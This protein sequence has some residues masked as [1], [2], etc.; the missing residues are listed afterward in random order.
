MGDPPDLFGA[1]V[2]LF[3]TN[4][5]ALLANF[6]GRRSA[7]AQRFCEALFLGAV[8]GAPEICLAGLMAAGA[9]SAPWLRAQGRLG[10]V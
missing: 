10:F 4:S 8:P 2:L 3:L 5:L 7:L 9:V 6:P 1:A